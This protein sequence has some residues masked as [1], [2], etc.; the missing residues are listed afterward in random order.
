MRES[1]NRV[2][3]WMGF[4]L[5]AGLILFSGCGKDEKPVEV[6]TSIS[7]IR[8]YDSALAIAQEE[9]ERLVLDFYTSWCSWCKRLDS[10]TFA[11]STV[12]AASASM[13][14]AKIDAEEDTITAQRYS[15]NSFPTVVLANSDG[16]EIDRIGGYLPPAKFL[17]TINDY[18][19]GIKTLDYY[20]QVADTSPTMEVHSILGQK[21]KARGK[22]DEAKEYYEKV[23]AADS[24]SGDTLVADAMLSIGGLYYRLKDYDKSVDQYDKVLKKFEDNDIKLEAILMKAYVYRQKGDTTKAIA[25]YEKVIKDFPD[26][27][28]LDRV[29]E[30]IEKLK[31]PPP[32]EEEEGQEG[33]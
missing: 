13:V 9:D 29:E 32:P 22:Y 10:V 33:K 27:E 21:Y 15:V 31:N 28:K 14:F 19:N 20:L 25:T 30:M 5:L 2:L 12:I 24:V 16:T 7:F 26:F 23:L 11:D 18:L 17:E 3:V 1:C 8:D 4:F 6:P